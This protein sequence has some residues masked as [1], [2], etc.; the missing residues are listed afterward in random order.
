MNKIGIGDY[1]IANCDIGNI[2]RQSVGWV[3]NVSGDTRKVYFIGMNKMAD[4]VCDKLEYLDIKKTG[5]PYNKKICN[6]CHIIKDMKEF[7]VN[8]TD[9]KGV[10]TRRPSCKICRIEIDGT[11]LKL[12]ER[13]RFNAIKPKDIFTCPVCKKTSI[14]GITAKLVIDHDHKTGEGRGWICD[15]CNTGLGRFKDD[16]QL[17]EA[18]ISYL[19]S[20]VQK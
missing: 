8:Q 12:S 11:P 2:K 14:V 5:K 18:I 7:D 20:F 3:K 17:I 15:S 4:V 10:K 1:V 19:K 9:A 16:I 6:I 13:K